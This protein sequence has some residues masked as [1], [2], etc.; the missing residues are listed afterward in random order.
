M[1]QDTT[2]I[3]RAVVCTWVRI[4]T[5]LLLCLWMGCDGRSRE[6]PDPGQIA[7][8]ESGWQYRELPTRHALWRTTPRKVA[9]LLLDLA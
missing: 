3:G 5:L 4:F 2:V 8:L 9:D 1:N 6:L 7:T